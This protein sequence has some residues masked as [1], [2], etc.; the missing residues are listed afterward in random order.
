MVTF[1]RQS[2]WTWLNIAK[3]NSLF[4]MYLIE[5]LQPKNCEIQA[6]LKDVQIFQHQLWWGHKRVHQIILSNVTMRLTPS[7]TKWPANNLKSICCWI[8]CD[9]VEGIILITITIFITIFI[10]RETVVVVLCPNQRVDLSGDHI[11]GWQSATGLSVWLANH[12]WSPLVTATKRNSEG[13][14]P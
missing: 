9:M 8:G 14:F 11:I 6:N 4:H 10:T 3:K 12:M 13:G 2:C 1:W 7:D 5:G